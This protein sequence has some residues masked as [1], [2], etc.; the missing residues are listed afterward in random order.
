MTLVLV[1]AVLGRNGALHSSMVG[2]SAA[3][4]LVRHHAL[5]GRQVVWAVLGAHTAAAD[6]AQRFPRF[7]VLAYAR[8]QRASLLYAALNLT[9]V[10]FLV[11]Y[12]KLMHACSGVVHALQSVGAT[13]SSPSAQ[14]SRCCALASAN[15]G[16]L[17]LEKSALLATLPRRVY[18]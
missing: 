4:E 17:P 6:F 5:K 7:R 9:S 8:C 10:F 12:P 1:W 2:P 14:L 11:F 13:T 3:A 15:P 18:R 16:G